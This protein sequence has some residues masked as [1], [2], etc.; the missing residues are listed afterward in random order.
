[1]IDILG[2]DLPAG[3]KFIGYG[4]GGVLENLISLVGFD[5]LCFML[6]DDAELVQDIVD[7]IGSRLVGH[8]QMLAQFDTIEAMIS[9][10]VG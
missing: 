5:N 9:A 3:M 2:R 10:A 7:A 1:M 6:I 4:P 8:Y